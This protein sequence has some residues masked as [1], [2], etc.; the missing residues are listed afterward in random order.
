MVRKIAL[1]LRFAIFHFS[2]VLGT[3]FFPPCLLTENTFIFS[4]YQSE[5]A[6]Q[7]R[8]KGH[9]ADEGVARKLRDYTRFHR[10]QGRL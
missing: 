9:A 7:C 10:T 4:F 6:Q 5:G 3:L 8:E 2:T 1:F